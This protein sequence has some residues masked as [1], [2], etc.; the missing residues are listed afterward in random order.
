MEE[1]LHPDTALA[2][3]LEAA[4]P[5]APVPVTLDRALDLVAA[6]DV[7]AA[8]DVPLADVS[9]MDGFAVRSADVAGASRE[10]PAL[11]R[12]VD[13]VPAGRTAVRAL[14]AGQAIRIMTG[15]PV[16][17]GAD[18]VVRQEDTRGADGPGAGS[19]EALVPAAPGD[20]VFGRGED[21][22]KGDLV[23]ARGALL[24]P[25]ELGVLA[26]VGVWRVMAHPR[27]RVAVIATGDELVAPHEAVAPGQVRSSNSLTLV[28]QARR[29][30]AEPVDLGIARDSLE[31]ITGRLREA[32]DCEVVIASG[33][34][35]RGD[36]DYSEPAL[37]ALGVTIRF[38][39]VAIK[40]GKPVLFG[41]LG[42]RLFFGLPGNPVASMLT[43]DLF[44]R[45][46]L[47]RM[48]GL[49]RLARREAEAVLACD[50]K[51]KETGKRYYIR[52][53]YQRDENGAVVTS[54]GNQGS[55]VLSSM[56]RAN[57]VLVMDMGETALAKGSRVKV[58][59]MDETEA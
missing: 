47:L 51:K 12:V 17:A 16:P 42:R 38:H 2:I 25:Q 5:L 15:G 56:S 55:S 50:L 20:H 53:R 9:A 4:E 43:F 32:G 3:V 29:H 24:R 46:A 23:V 58:W 35:A 37:V 21:I 31:E 19:V 18:A 22:R 7:R 10:R 33:G 52:M 57:A 36:R 13:Y 49:A 39:R 8:E 1:L 54:T 45:P 41:A 44:V 40:P 48:R 26:S 14:A 6:E 30:G 59:L 28:N 34:S 11:L 27:P